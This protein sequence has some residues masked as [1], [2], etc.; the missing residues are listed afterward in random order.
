MR[1]TK[2]RFIM[3]TNNFNISSCL[4]LLLVAFIMVGCASTMPELSKAAHNGDFEAVRLLLEKDTDVNHKHWALNIASSE[5]HYNIVKLLLEKGTDVNSKFDNGQTPLHTASFYGQ[6]N[7]V[8]LLI[9]NGADVNAKNKY[10]G[11]PLIEAAGRGHYGVA[12]L[13]LENGVDIRPAVLVPPRC[14]GNTPVTVAL[15]G[16]EDKAWCSVMSI[17]EGQHM[18]VITNSKVISRDHKAYVLMGPPPNINFYAVDSGV[19]FVRFNVDVREK[20]LESRFHVW[21]EHFSDTGD[22]TTIG[23]Y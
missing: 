10:G 3:I 17:S 2:K 14:L 18:V 22:I 8:K 16:K 11:T 21:L 1:E 12:K 6:Y 7:I 20:S 15:D 13:I 5:G 9:E 23:R 4:L 19:Y